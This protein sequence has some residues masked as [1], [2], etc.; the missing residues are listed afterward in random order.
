MVKKEQITGYIVDIHAI[1]EWPR[2][3]YW[4]RARIYPREC[5]L[6]GCALESGFAIIED[7]QTLILLD[8]QATSLITDVLSLSRVE[9]GV[10]LIVER[11]QHNGS[12]RTVLVTEI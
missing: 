12:M 2:Y 1:R 4:E 3:E 10:R 11:E 7:D 6:Q 9:T 5:N 8:T